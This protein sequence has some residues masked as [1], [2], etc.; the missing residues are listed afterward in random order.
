M[1]LSASQR[2]VL[3][4][5]AFGLGT[6]FSALGGVVALTVVFLPS[7]GLWPR[8]EL[9]SMSALL[10][11]I[12]LVVSIARLAGHRFFTPQDIDG[13]G[14]TSGTTRAKLLQ[15]LLQNTLE[16]LAIAVP[17]YAA[18][19]V[20]APERLLLVMPAC[21][22]LFVVGRSLYFWGYARGAA[23]RAFGFALTFYP[24]VVMLVCAIV[25]SVLTAAT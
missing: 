20:L 10:A 1:V 2:G 5:M 15:S 4:G 12:T 23:H 6:T 8:V 21:A 19:A 13:S 16:Q 22:A 7:Q 18:W 9:F 17:V 14:L 3:K 25:L 24:T 11:T